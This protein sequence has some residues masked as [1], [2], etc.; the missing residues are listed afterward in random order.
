M[1]RSKWRKNQE[2]GAVPMASYART[3]TQMDTVAFG[4]LFTFMAVDI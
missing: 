1:I 2:Q 3:V 4:H